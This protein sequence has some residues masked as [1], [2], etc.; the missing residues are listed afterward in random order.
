MYKRNL[1]HNIVFLHFTKINSTV[2]S[3]PNEESEDAENFPPQ[4]E[5]VRSKNSRLLLVSALYIHSRVLSYFTK[6]HKLLKL[7]SVDWDC[8]IANHESGGRWDKSVVAYLRQSI[9]MNHK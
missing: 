7:R 2:T 5:D 6:L 3:T 4:Y 9:G 8:I 1:Y